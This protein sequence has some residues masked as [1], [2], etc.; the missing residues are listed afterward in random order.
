MKGR[1][2]R[3]LLFWIQEKT[4]VKVKNLVEEKK[5]EKAPMPEKYK[6]K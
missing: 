6:E 3:R 1:H 4:I 5:Q 2:R